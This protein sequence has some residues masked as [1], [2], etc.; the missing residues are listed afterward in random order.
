MKDWGKVDALKD[1][2]EEIPLHEEIDIDDHDSYRL[3]E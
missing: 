3:G 2:E 1:E